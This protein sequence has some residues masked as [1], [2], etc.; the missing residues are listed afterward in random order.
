MAQKTA[1]WAWLRRRHAGQVFH[2]DDVSGARTKPT[3][4]SGSGGGVWA[5]HLRHASTVCRA[6]SNTKWPPGIT[7][8]TSQGEL[9]SVRGTGRAVYLHTEWT[10]TPSDPSK[11]LR[12]GRRSGSRKVASGCISAGFDLL[13]ERRQIVNQ[14]GFCFGRLVRSLSGAQRQQPYT[15]TPLLSIVGWEGH[16]KADLTAI[17]AAQKI[18]VTCV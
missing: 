7:R 5:P 18:F 13:Q 11:R 8:M 3:I 6:N 14:Q 1:M 2:G 12:T 16:T 10:S 4:T 9:V 17:T 15:W